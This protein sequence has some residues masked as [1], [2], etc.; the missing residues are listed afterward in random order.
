VLELWLELAAF[1]LQDP[2]PDQIPGNVVL[3]RQAVQTLAGQKLLGDL[4]LEAD[5]E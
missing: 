5:V 2:D 3:S 1:V 4:T